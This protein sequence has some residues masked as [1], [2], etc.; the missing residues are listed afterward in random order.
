MRSRG[1][2]AQYKGVLVEYFDMEGMDPEVLVSLINAEDV[3]TQ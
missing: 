1:R 3:I 2:A